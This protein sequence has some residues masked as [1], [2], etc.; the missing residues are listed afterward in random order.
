MILFFYFNKIDDYCQ[1][2]CLPKVSE[3]FE[4]QLRLNPILKKEYELYQSTQKMIELFVEEEP[5]IPF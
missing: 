1:G 2:K 5:E 4:R 3:K